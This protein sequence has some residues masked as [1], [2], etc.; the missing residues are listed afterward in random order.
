[1]AIV[2]I[3]FAVIY[4]FRTWPAEIYDNNIDSTLYTNV[5]EL[6]EGSKVSQPVYVYTEWVKQPG[7]DNE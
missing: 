2:G 6:T 5:G 4:S 7:V 3:L 1:M